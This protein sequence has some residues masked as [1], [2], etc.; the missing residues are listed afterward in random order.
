MSPL[1]RART[2]GRRHPGAAVVALLVVIAALPLALGWQLLTSSSSTSA[3][4][5]DVLRGA[6]P[7]AVDEAAGAVPAGATVFDDEFPAVARL[8]PALLDALRRAAT[9][10][11]DDGVGLV[12]NS[13]W[14]S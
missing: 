1:E 5:L 12:V 14:R 3:S 8:D 4:P 2:P 11:A 9:A 7:G 6:H 10:A 13:G